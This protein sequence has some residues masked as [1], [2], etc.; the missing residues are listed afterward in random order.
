MSGSRTKNHIKF[1]GCDFGAQL[2]EAIL[3]AQPESD[4]RSTV[5]SGRDRK[6]FRPAV[7][8]LC[9]LDHQKNERTTELVNSSPSHLSVQ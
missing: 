1:V 4:Q 7:R 3:L 2:C 8:H 9:E 5:S 6:L